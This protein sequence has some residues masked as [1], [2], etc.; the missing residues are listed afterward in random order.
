[1]WELYDMAPIHR[2]YLFITSIFYEHKRFVVWG[3]YYR[4]IF[5]IGIWWNRI[6]SENVTSRTSTAT[7][8]LYLSLHEE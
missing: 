4:W 1:M 3:E 7:I 2:L 6:L 8:I 5:V